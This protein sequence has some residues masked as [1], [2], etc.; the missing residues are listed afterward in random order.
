[1]AEEL[2]PRVRLAQEQRAELAEVKA[3]YKMAH[4][5]AG[6]IPS[7]NVKGNVWALRTTIIKYLQVSHMHK[8][9]LT[10]QFSGT[11]SFPQLNWGTDVATV[12]RQSENNPGRRHKS[13]EESL[14]S[15]CEKH[16]LKAEEKRTAHTWCR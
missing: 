5:V 15:H 13:R 12:P 16:K 11:A 14:D 2:W 7:E 3:D 1:M 10:V 8:K 4:L 6:K 9:R